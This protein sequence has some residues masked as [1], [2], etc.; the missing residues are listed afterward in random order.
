MLRWVQAMIRSQTGEEGFSRHRQERV[1]RRALTRL[2]NTD[3]EGCSKTREGAETEKEGCFTVL[4]CTRKNAHTGF[5]MIAQTRKGAH[6]GG[7]TGV[8]TRHRRLRRKGAQGIVKG[9][10]EAPKAVK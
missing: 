7:N 9:R 1:L 2:A 6:R 5:T 8:Q 4:A 10:S 3:E